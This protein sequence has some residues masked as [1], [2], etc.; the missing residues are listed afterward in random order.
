[1][2]G[3][4]CEIRIDTN[5]ILNVFVFCK[6]LKKSYNAFLSKV[7]LRNKKILKSTAIIILWI[8]YISLNKNINIK[9]ILRFLICKRRCIKIDQFLL[10]CV[11]HIH[12]KF[13]KANFL[14]T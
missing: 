9:N 11:L 7:S 2:I 10:K 12:L 1:M 8:V 6:Q 13:K 14:T 4:L 3:K 5:F